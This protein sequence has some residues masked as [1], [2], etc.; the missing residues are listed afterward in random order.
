M[1][2]AAQ[3][4]TAL[5]LCKRSGE[6]ESVFVLL[7]RISHRVWLRLGPQGREQHLPASGSVHCRSYQ[8]RTS[9]HTRLPPDRWGPAKRPR[10]SA[11][12]G[13]H[14]VFSP[15]QGY[16]HQTNKKFLPGLHFTRIE[17]AG[18]ELQQARCDEGN[19]CFHSEIQLAA[20]LC[21]G[22]LTFAVLVADCGT[23]GPDLI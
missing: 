17:T 3:Q 10:T 2:A 11:H 4:M 21:A 15:R 8:E 22:P 18:L 19:L 6:T 20:C 23:A 9:L 7:P 5:S 12:L 13:G 14:A 1:I 16:Y